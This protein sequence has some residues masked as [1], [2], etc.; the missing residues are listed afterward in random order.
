MTSTT[1]DV[2]NLRIGLGYDSHRLGPGGPLR[3]G[4]IDVPAEV[5]A[6]GHS[7]ADVLLHAITDGLLGALCAGDI[8]RLFPDTAAENADRDS[9]DFLLAALEKVNQ[10]GMGIVNLD[11]VIL[12]ERPKMAPHIDAMRTHIAAMLGID[13][14]QVGIK[15]KT[16]EGVGE[17]GTGQSI[18]T[19]VVVLLAGISAAN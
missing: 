10:R 8:G 9:R 12:A 2:P 14:S 13:P 19:R 15:A 6:I 7:D 11:C 1:A 18:A 4:G 5:H 3:I 16:G 17:I